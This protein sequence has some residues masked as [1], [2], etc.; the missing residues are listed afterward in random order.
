MQRPA[1]IGGQKTAEWALAHPQEAAANRSKGGT[2]A[3][4][5][6]EA[7][8]DCELAVQLPCCNLP[9]DLV[10]ATRTLA[11]SIV[12][13]V[14]QF[15]VCAKLAAASAICAMLDYS[16][17]IQRGLVPGLRAFSWP[18]KPCK[19]RASFKWTSDSAAAVILGA[20]LHFIVCAGC[21][22]C[23]GGSCQYCCTLDL[24]CHRFPV[25]A[26]LT[27]HLAIC[28]DRGFCMQPW[29]PSIA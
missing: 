26:F 29:T 7:A 1:R 13:T 19:Q 16:A 5:N 15:R 20:F 17:L 24:I 4:A 28:C 21:C 22:S 23:A 25:P 6:A 2:Q 11:L 12:R 9:A 14:G 3:A 18:C 27:T 10:P 8:V